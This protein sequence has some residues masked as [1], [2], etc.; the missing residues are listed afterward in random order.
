MEIQG[1][2][3]VQVLSK[4]LSD[5]TL[6]LV[7]KYNLD[8]SY[9]STPMCD[10]NN[11][12]TGTTFR[13]VYKF[14]KSHYN[15]FNTTP[16]LLTIQRSYP[17]FQVVEVT[18]SEDYLIKTLKEEK[19]ELGFNKFWNAAGDIYTK[20][21]SAKAIQYIQDN[22]TGL[23]DI[24][25]GNIGKDLIHEG[26]DERL[27]A[28]K[29]AKANPAKT[30]V[31]TGLKELDDVIGGWGRYG[32][33]AII[34]ARMGSAKTFLLLKMLYEAWLKGENICLYEPEMDSNSIGYRWDSLV[35]HFSNFKL[36]RGKEVDKNYD[37]Y[38][39]NLKN[40]AGKFMFVE[41][42]DFDYTTTVSKL[43]AFCKQH[44]VTL[45]AIDGINAEY[46]TDERGSRFIRD[47]QKVGHICTDLL[48]MS[49][50]LHIPVIAVVQAQRIGKDE[51]LG[52]NTIAGSIEI[53]KIAT[54][55]MSINKKKES[56]TID[57]KIDKNRNAMDYKKLTYIVDLDKGIWSYS[58]TGDDNSISSS[59]GGG[60]DLN[61][62][63][64]QITM[65]RPS[66]I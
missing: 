61:I 13:D 31:T 33:L 55:T 14:I 2:T 11:K 44:N 57:I 56:N 35:E 10:E 20:Q 34:Q 54:L 12:P 51:E 42:R 7:E 24:P 6:N 36:R 60:D 50:E 28:Y 65:R 4:I 37:E 26:A 46:L 49:K 64:S 32:E 30:L 9:F 48:N 62:D 53:P 1:V 19:Q 22:L 39:Q 38:I 5:K 3:E 15:Q 41:P 58:Q 18:D 45:L 52:N 47:D 66:K 21:G 40:N 63:D 8:E 29:E 43:R 17:S 27:A 25:I 59:L 23:L 16:D